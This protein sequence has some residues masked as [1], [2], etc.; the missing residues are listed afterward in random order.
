MGTSTSLVFWL[1]AFT[2]LTLTFTAITA[3]DIKGHLKSE[4]MILP[5]DK[6]CFNS[7]YPLK[8]KE[9][10]QNPKEHS[11]FYTVDILS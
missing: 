7:I 2:A 10:P 1:T 8:R 3:G 5:E 6:K 9:E 4:G 11:V